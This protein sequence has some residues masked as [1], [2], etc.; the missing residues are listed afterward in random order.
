MSSTKSFARRAALAAAPL[1]AAILWGYPQA[2]EAQHNE[3]EIF[4]LVLFEQLEGELEEGG[5]AR[6]DGSAW[7]GGDYNR[8]WLETEGDEEREELQVLYSRLITPFWNMQIGLRANQHLAD[9]FASPRGQVVISLHGLA[10]LLFEVDA[11]AFISP[12]GDITA[13]GEGTFQL[14]LTQ[15]LI[16]EPSAELTLV[17]FDGGAPGVGA[18]E[19]EI[20][21]G[22]R[23]RY[24]LRRELAPY[25]GLNFER[26]LLQET[27]S[28]RPQDLAVV[29]GVR[30]FL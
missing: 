26:N 7:V 13:R 20:E 19:S 23:L 14:Y 29:A 9:P 6:W 18:D 8:L 4:W 12:E 28:G 30:A 25:L 10:P 24:E 27:T 3:D 16:A 17:F 1:L 22:L 11:E 5:A 15:R 2:A 21:L